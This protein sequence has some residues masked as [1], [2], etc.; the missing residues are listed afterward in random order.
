MLHLKLSL[1]LA[2]A[3]D[4]VL[5]IMHL[6]GNSDSADCPSRMNAVK[7]TILACL[8]VMKQEAKFQTILLCITTNFAVLKW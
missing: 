4:L 2:D 1:S 6:G 7:I 8:H 3:K 5:H